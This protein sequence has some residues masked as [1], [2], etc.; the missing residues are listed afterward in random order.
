[1]VRGKFVKFD[2]E[3]LIRPTREGHQEALRRGMVENKDAR[4]RFF[5]PASMAI[6]TFIAF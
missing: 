2:Q 4:N 5:T 3:L 6:S 1:M